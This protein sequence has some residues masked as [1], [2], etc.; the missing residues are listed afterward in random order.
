MTVFGQN[1]MILSGRVKDL[2]SNMP[3]EAVNVYIEKLKIGD[4]SDSL[5]YYRIELPT[6][7]DIKIVFSH[8]SYLT[9]LV[10][11]KTSKDT[12]LNI[13]L[14][15]KNIELEEMK[16]VFDSKRVTGN[17]ELGKLELR[18]EDILNLPSLFG[19]PDIINSI[20]SLPG[21]SKGNDGDGG[22]YIR[23]GEAG[24]NLVILDNIEILNPSH[25][26]G[27]YS[28]FNPFTTQKVSVY[29]GNSPI[30]YGRK[31]SS[32]VVVQSFNNDTNRI[33]RVFN[34]GNLVSDIGVLG[35]SKDKKISYTIG[36]RK[37]YLEAYSKI[38]S[39]FLDTEKKEDLTKNMLGFYDFNGLVSFHSGKS[40]Q[41]NLSWYWGKDYLNL[42]SRQIFINT[43]IGWQNRGIALSSNNRI[44]PNDRVE[45]IL[46]CTNYSF[47]F[48]GALIDKIINLHTNYSHVK[49]NSYIVHSWNGNSFI[50]GFASTYY[51][52]EPKNSE[53]V[54]N[55][56]ENVNKVKFNSFEY[57]FYSSIGLKPHPKWLINAGIQMKNFLFLGPYE[58]YSENDSPIFSYHRKEIVRSVMTPLFSFSTSYEINPNSVLRSSY[59]FDSQ[60]IHQGMVASIALPAD[61][62]VPTSR[63]I[64]PEYSHSFSAGVNFNSIFHH[65]YSLII[66]AYY[67]SMINLLIFKMNYN[68]ARE[69]QNIEDQFSSGVGW[70][71]GIEFSLAKTQGRLTGNFSTTFSKSRRKFNDFNDGRWFDSKYDRVVDV[72]LFGKYVINPTCSLNLNWVFSGG[73]KTTLPSGRYWMMGSIMNDFGGMNNIQLPSYHRLD[74]GIDIKM[75]KSRLKESVLNIAFLNV[76]NRSNP[77][78]VNYGIS[79][80]E[81]NPYMLKIFAR[82]VSLIPFLPSISW[83]FIF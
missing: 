62:Y 83:K 63:L 80:P 76:Y 48:K 65:N 79:A 73:M 55:L 32:V 12:I 47:N 61:L 51:H 57:N 36:L 46:S 56:S 40:S 28:V 59:M 21:V 72:S 54:S 25:I 75:I 42:D 10:N 81:D 9:T 44:G 82:Q 78:F 58:Y 41:Q 37:S 77:F 70:A 64:E 60:N 71:S 33:R 34:L 69:V 53:I 17:T 3:I 49:L 15:G 24:Q 67:K 6:G 43:D 31:L 27:M 74:I 52:L 11:F 14:F 13:D 20:K 30:N 66:D 8:A 29:K 4:I 26:L 35:T 50:G 45:A 68:T 23:G 39:L 5:G 19:S 18:Q 38:G 2:S 16:V 22:L 7:F 1:K